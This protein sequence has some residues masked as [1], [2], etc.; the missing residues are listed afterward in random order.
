MEQGERPLED[1]VRPVPMSSLNNLRSRKVLVTGHTG[2]KGGWLMSMLL[3]LGAEPVGYSLEPPSAPS[4]FVETGLQE[5]C[6]DIRAD[7]LDISRLKKVMREEQPEVVFHLAAQPLVIRSYQ[8]PLETFNVNV[9]GTANVLEAVRSCDSVR[10]CVCITSDKCYE[11][12]ELD[13]GYTEEDRLGGADPY[14]ASKGAAELVISSYR[15]SFFKERPII[16]SVRAG[17]VIGGGDW[18]DKR[19]VPDIVDC[20]N[21]NRPLILRNPDSVR[22]WQHVL[23]PLNGYLTLASRMLDGDVNVSDAWNFGP[24]GE[25]RTV[26]QVAE[27]MMSAWGKVVPIEIVPGKVQESR[28]LR[29]DC[30]K[31]RSELN[32]KPVLDLDNAIRYTVGWYKGWSEGKDVFDITNK[33]IDAFWELSR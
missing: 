2:F 20:L 31:A 17:N 26:R 6:M 9:I 4:F 27:M 14:S 28:M 29:L 15:R 8:E 10:A 12:L 23:D 13:R 19:I 16:A 7:V 25:T 1:V 21:S 33:Q 30:S 24:D 18:A 22:P 11:N 5:R 3:R 32:W